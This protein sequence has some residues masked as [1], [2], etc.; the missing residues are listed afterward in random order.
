MPAG[1]KETFLSKVT[2]RRESNW[3]SKTKQI[4][5]EMEMIEEICKHCKYFLL[6]CCGDEFKDC[7]LKKSISE[8]ALDFG[9]MLRSHGES[10][11][12]YTSGA[13]GYEKGA[14]EQKAIDEDAIHAIV[15]EQVLKAIEKQKAIDEANPS[16]AVIMRILNAIGYEEESW[17]PIV[18][19]N[20]KA[21]E[22]DTK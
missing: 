5:K 22:E 9:K 2:F 21:M 13:A 14:T 18:R 3:V 12:S 10:E 1:G 15:E 11:D 19:K 7:K 17:I 6:C 20:L 16:D 8:R 4:L